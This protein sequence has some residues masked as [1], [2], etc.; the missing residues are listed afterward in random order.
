MRG[1]SQPVGVPGRQRFLKPDQQSRSVPQEED[2]LLLEDLHVAFQPSQGRA[3]VELDAGLRQTLVRQL[4]EPRLRAQRLDQSQ[5]FLGVDR[6]GDVP[7]HARRQAAFP[8]AAHGRGGQSDDRQVRLRQSFRGRGFPVWPAGRPFPASGRPS[9]RC[10]ASR[11]PSWPAPRGRPPPGTRRGRVF[12]GSGRPTGDWP[13]YRQPR[14]PA[15]GSWHATARGGGSDLSSSTARPPGIVKGKQKWNVLPLP[16]WLSTH[17]R[18][19]SSETNWAEIVKPQ[20]GS[21]ITP[22][23]R[24]VGLRKRFKDARQLVLRNADSRVADRKMDAGLVA[25]AGIQRSRSR[26]LRPCSVNLMALSIKIEQDLP[27]AYRIADDDR[28]QV[29]G[30]LADAPAVLSGARRAPTA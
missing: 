28:R 17:S 25:R 13:D 15:S 26:R 12:P 8:V 30:H 4:G 24:G 23:G 1:R 29:R 7:V 6:L 11:A 3:E 27:Q 5:Q 22:A 2:H 19:S 9:R 10:P 16:T 20:P 21:A 14:E 18:P